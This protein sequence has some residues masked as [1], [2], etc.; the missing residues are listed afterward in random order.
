MSYWIL[1]PEVAGE[2]GEGTVLE[3]CTHPPVGHRLHYE[4]RGWL[5]LRCLQRFLLRH[6]DVEEFDGRSPLDTSS[7]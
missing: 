7:P 4:F 5:V 3:P 6:C 1:E 2:I